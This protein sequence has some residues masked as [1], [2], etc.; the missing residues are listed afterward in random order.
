MSIYSV[1][2]IVNYLKTA[3]F[4]HDT[5]DI[6]DDG[7]SKILTEYDVFENLNEHEKTLLERDLRG[8]AEQNEFREAARMATSLGADPTDI[9]LDQPEAEADENAE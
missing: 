3:G 6:D 7:V 1:Y 2:R 4:Y 9:Y 5:F 8:L